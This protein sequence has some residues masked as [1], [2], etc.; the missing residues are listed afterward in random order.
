MLPPLMWRPQFGRWSKGKQ[1]VLRPYA[2]SC[3]I[4]PSQ[5]EAFPEFVMKEQMGLTRRERQLIQMISRG[6]TN[7]EIAVT[8][9]LSEQTVKNHVHRILRK[10][11]AGD[12]LVAVECRVQG[13]PQA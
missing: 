2:G 5:R 4:K 11:G 8:L 3:S 12:H 6:L 13:L 10:L 7:K 1:S 9:H